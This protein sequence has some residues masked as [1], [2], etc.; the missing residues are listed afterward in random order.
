MATAL[1]FLTQALHSDGIAGGQLWWLHFFQRSFATGS[2][3]ARMLPSPEAQLVA[4]NSPC[5]GG[6][7]V[8]GALQQQKSLNC[9]SLLSVRLH[10]S[11]H[12]CHQADPAGRAL[13]CGQEVP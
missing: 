11:L 13:R 1:R 3:T 8:T 12:F 9:P 6:H 7:L 2:S 5:A 4:Q 10:C